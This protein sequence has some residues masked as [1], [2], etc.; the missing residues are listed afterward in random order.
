[1]LKLPDVTLVCYEVQAHELAT[2]TL[3][4]AMEKIEFGD[5]VIWSDKRLDLDC[6]QIL[7]NRQTPKIHSA[8]V[9]WYSAHKEVK[10]SHMLNMEWDSGVLNTDRWMPGY[11]DYDYVGAPWP[12]H[13]EHRVGN[14]GFSLRSKRLMEYLS[15]HVEWFPVQHPD[16]DALCRQYRDALEGIGFHWAPETLARLFSF[17]R[18]EPHNTFGF[19]GLFNFPQ[20][21]DKDEFLSRVNMLPESF[22]SRPEWTEMMRNMALVA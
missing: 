14:G 4:D 22:Q 13:K 15:N 6:R 21:F 7:V 2:K 11:L 12:W 20:V 18:D 1:M 9:M 10:T 3:R 5:V 17:E 19:H 8:M 16:D